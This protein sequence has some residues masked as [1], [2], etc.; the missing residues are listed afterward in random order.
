MKIKF[1]F[2]VIILLFCIFNKNYVYAEIGVKSSQANNL[3]NSEYQ[4][5]IKKESVSLKDEMK[6]SEESKIYSDS[7]ILYTNNNPNKNNI[8]VCVNA[9]HGTSGGE[10]VKTY[11][12]PDHT[13]KII[14][15][16]TAKGALQASAVS[17]GMDFDDDV[18]ESE[19]TLKE[20][21]L[22]KDLLLSN[23]YNVLMIRESDDIQLDNVA[24][25]VIANYYANCH[26]SIHWDST[27]SD[28]GAF[29]MATPKSDEA[30]LAMEPVASNYKKSD[31]LGEA[32]IKGLKNNNVKIFK[33]GYIEQDLTQTSY[34]TIPSV[35]IE[36]G[37]KKS[38]ISDENLIILATGLLEGISQ[39]HNENEITQPS[40]NESN[41]KLNT[42]SNTDSSN[43]KTGILSSPIEKLK[44]EFLELIDFFL[45]LIDVVQNIVNLFLTI[46][47]GI[48][49]DATVLYQ[50]STVQTNSKVNNYINLEN[51]KFDK[52]A[53]LVIDGTEEGYSKSTLI[54]FAPVE[55]YSIISGEVSNFD[56]NFMTGQLNTKKHPTDSIWTKVRNIIASVIHIV[57]YISIA[58]LII[59]LI[60]HGIHLVTNTIFPNEKAKHIG[61]LNNFYKAVFML[62]G[63][64]VL[65]ALCIFLV[66][67][68][69]SFMGLKN[70]IHFPYSVSVKSANCTFYSNLTGYVRY[71]SQITTTEKL[72]TKVLYLFTYLF[73]VVSNV[74]VVIMMLIRLGWIIVLSI[75]G[76]IIA[77]AY[78][79]QIE[80]VLGLTYVDWVK[81]Y[82]KWSSIPVVIS[83]GYIVLIKLFLK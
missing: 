46:D 27:N 83:V 50:P 15:G 6:Y 30:Y 5:N 13:A 81:K 60:W 7:A 4:Q 18:H 66:N 59:T 72:G 38:D 74:F 71:L 77:S 29:Y 80:K 22:L 75:L 26:I 20:A 76:P 32:L 19:I 8:T 62:V 49:K 67:E 41:T 52:D 79:L 63:S 58:F 43:K 56:I 12:H 51:N 55:T 24:R 31:L 40:V 3:M 35:D 11:C 48:A 82:I 45:G 54:P 23:G 33:N 10:N 17:S 70:G 28:K 21:L 34:S 44:Q 73:L 1:K 37:D 57:I 65:M 53:D 68:L 61:G 9:G 64:V 42:N 16:S 47:L 78:A 14:G 25:T 36:L 2:L 39:Y 69:I